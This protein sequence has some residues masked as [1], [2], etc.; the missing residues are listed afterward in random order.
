MLGAFFIGRFALFGIF[1]VCLSVQVFLFLFLLHFSLLTNRDAS[2]Y[3]G[4]CLLC[5]CNRLQ[6]VVFFD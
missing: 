2:R 1:I 6:T 5:Y 3:L 4:Q